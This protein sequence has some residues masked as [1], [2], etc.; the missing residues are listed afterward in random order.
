VNGSNEGSFSRRNLLLGG[1]AIVAAGAGAYALVRG[2]LWVAAP[3][4]KPV[5]YS[6]D[7]TGQCVL[8][9]TM[10]EGPYYVDEA[11]VRRDVRDGRPG[12]EFL[13]RLKIADAK[14]CEGTP[15]AIVDIWHCDADGT[16][17][18]AAP[19]G[20]EDR[21]PAGH[22]KPING[23]RF[24]RGRQIADVDGIVEF[25]TIYPGWYNG[26]TPHIHFKVHVGEREVATSQLFF[27]NE[28]S[29]E[30]YSKAPYAAHGMADTINDSDGVLRNADRADGVWPKVVRD[31]ERLVGTL[32][33]GVVR[34]TDLAV[35]AVSP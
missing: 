5:S 10:T 21:T 22:L 27:A 6:F 33:V 26:R 31:G 19:L 34:A 11:L 25:V 2:L 32:T 23:K 15:G 35:L 4:P 8:S 30:V 1:G 3:Q 29:A 12:T 20:R 24:L 16:Y 13:L 28:L 7:E 17:S 18:A 14:T 9:A